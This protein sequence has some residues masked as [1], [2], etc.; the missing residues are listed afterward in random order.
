MHEDFLW[1]ESSGIENHRSSE[2]KPINQPIVLAL[3]KMEQLLETLQATSLTKNDF[4]SI[5]RDIQSVQ[6]TVSVTPKLLK[7]IVDSVRETRSDLTSKLTQSQS[8]SAAVMRLQ[9]QIRHLEQM[10]IQKVD[11]HTGEIMAKIEIQPL[12]GS[13]RRVSTEYLNVKI[14]SEMQRLNQTVEKSLKH[15]VDKL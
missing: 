2:E 6:S 5:L 3:G 7:D 9:D 1:F 4:Q 12:E 10:L 14:T 8:E 15:S 13:D 11:Q